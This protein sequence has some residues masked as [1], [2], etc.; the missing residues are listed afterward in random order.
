MSPATVNLLP[1]CKLLLVVS[2][3]PLAD[4]DRFIAYLGDSMLELRLCCRLLKARTDQHPLLWQYRYHRA[5][6]SG[7]QRVEEW[8][9]VYWCARSR[10]PVDSIPMQSAALLHRIDWRDVYR[11][12]VTTEQNW[13]HGRCVSTTMALP[14]EQ[15]YNYLDVRK[16]MSTVFSFP[17][18]SGDAGADDAAYGGVDER[19][20]MV[21]PGAFVPNGR[22]L[23]SA[24]THGAAEELAPTATPLDMRSPFGNPVAM[25]SD[26][27][28]AVLFGYADLTE[29]K[30]YTR[31]DYKLRYVAELPPGYTRQSIN[32]QWMLLVR[33]EQ[34]QAVRSS[35]LLVWDL[36]NNQGY[37]KRIDAA[38]CTACIHEASSD[39]AIIYVAKIGDHASG[40]VEWA[41][42]RVSQHR[43]IKQ[44]HEG[45][46]ALGVPLRSISITAQECPHIKL[47]VCTARHGCARFIHTIALDKHRLG[48]ERDQVRRLAQQV[49]SLSNSRDGT[50][51]IFHRLLEERAG[52]LVFSDKLDWAEVC[53]YHHVIG[54]LFAVQRWSNHRRAFYLVDAKRGVTIRPIK[55]DEGCCTPH[56]LMTG[57]ITKSC[58][59]SSAVI[60]S[61]GAL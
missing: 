46:F 44:L 51:K 10:F 9:F 26:R 17:T 19:L 30:V 8:D 47:Y 7:P 22:R 28:V 39:S 31:G 13:R 52:E 2:H 60:E 36:E 42:H 34:Q 6:L 48:I 14:C 21:E 3:L 61:Y 25:L 23:K 49:A 53:E 37:T 33:Q 20:V 55:T 35:S 40:T 32:G 4:L 1:R 24:A 54:D 50:N 38:S 41:L 11:R 5:F 56:F 58:H 59:A 12:R 18:E 15:S 57:L 27:F 29:M 45:W 43:P 16:S